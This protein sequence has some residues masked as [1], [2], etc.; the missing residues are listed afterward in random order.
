MYGALIETV[1]KQRAEI[2]EKEKQLQESKLNALKLAKDQIE[3][4]SEIQPDLYIQISPD[5]LDRILNNIID[6]A[7]K[8]NKSDG[9]I[10]ISIKEMKDSIL[11]TVQDTGIGIRSDQLKHIFKPYYQSEYQKLI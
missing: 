11:L 10:K 7:I 4:T 6:N 3:L 9:R 2:S 1:S 8:Y 5:A